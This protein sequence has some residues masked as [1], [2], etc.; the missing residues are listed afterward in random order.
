MSL[1]LKCEQALGFESPGSS[2]LRV[3]HPVRRACKR[4]VLIDALPRQC[5]VIG[6]HGLHEAGTAGR[7]ALEGERRLAR[8]IVAQ[9]QQARV[10]LVKRSLFADQPCVVE[11]S[12]GSHIVLQMV[13]GDG[14]VEGN[15]VEGGI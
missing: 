15:T 4:L 7:G 11:R 3:H 9:Q 12:L 5:G 6:R 10:E 2:G 13:E 8:T 1:R 14:V